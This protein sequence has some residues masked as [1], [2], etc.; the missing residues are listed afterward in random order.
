[1]SDYSNNNNDETQPMHIYP[2]SEDTEANSPPP[3]P[4]WNTQTGYHNGGYPLPQKNSRSG[5]LFASA[6]FGAAIAILV[7]ILLSHANDFSQYFTVTAAQ[8][9]AKSVTATPLPTSTPTITPTVTATQ[10][11]GGVNPPAGF[12]PYFSQDGIWEIYQPQTAV[13]TPDQIDFSNETDSIIGF[14]LAQNEQVYVTV[15]SSSSLSDQDIFDAILQYLNSDMSSLQILQSPVQATAG[16]NSW[17]EFSF[18]YTIQGDTTR[19]KGVI[20]TM[21]FSNGSV[22]LLETAPRSKF[23]SVNEKYYTTMLNSFALLGQNN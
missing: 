22:I 21:Q 11:A 2:Y 18:L 23:T 15:N 16:G 6:L 8:P 20:Y 1:M 5:I 7:Y 12:T 10:G 4:I 17:V 9:T 3:P 14:S 13:I 19:M